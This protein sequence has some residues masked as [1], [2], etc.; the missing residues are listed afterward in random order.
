[1]FEEMRKSAAALRLE[2]KSDFVIDADSDHRSGG[3]RRNH[4][5]QTVAESLV[6]DG[7]LQGLH[8]PTSVKWD[9]VADLDEIPASLRSSQPAPRERTRAARRLTAR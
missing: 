7:N 1:M 2:A 5:A 3:I 6:F 9:L 4:H 8:A